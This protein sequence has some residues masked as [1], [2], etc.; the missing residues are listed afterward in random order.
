MLGIKQM[1]TKKWQ[2]YVWGSVPNGWFVVR[3]GAFKKHRVAIQLELELMIR[4]RIGFLVPGDIHG[5]ELVG[6][7]TFREKIWP[8]AP[9]CVQ[10][11]TQKVHV[12]AS[13]ASHFL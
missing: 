9:P 5:H 12:D 7:T 4:N 10:R 2:S 13:G 11:Y 6:L 3:D 8:P 1:P